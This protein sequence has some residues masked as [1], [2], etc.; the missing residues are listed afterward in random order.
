[1]PSF[2]FSQALT[3]NQLGFD[4]LTNWQLRT[5]PYQWARGAAVQLLAR[6]TDANTRITVNSGTT[7]IQQRSPIQGGGT[8]GVTPSVLNTPPT[9]WIAGPGDIIQLAIDEVAGGT[10]TVDGIITVEPM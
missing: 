5:I 7:T 6:A 1:M 8:A 9:T 10:P 3:A 4:P 2:P